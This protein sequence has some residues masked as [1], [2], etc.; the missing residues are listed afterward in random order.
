[1]SLK[2][3][4]TFACVAYPVYQ[5]VVNG[6]IMVL[7]WDIDGLSTQLRSSKDTL[8]RCK[9]EQVQEEPGDRKEALKSFASTHCDRMDIYHNQQLMSHNDAVELLERKREE[10]VYWKSISPPHILMDS[11]R[12]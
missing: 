4:I 11:C 7:N 9:L 3:M 2:M 6:K 12:S 10:L 5:T 8:T 1:M